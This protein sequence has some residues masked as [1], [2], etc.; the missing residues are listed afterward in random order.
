LDR[1]LSTILEAIRNLFG[2]VG[3]S[4]WLKDPASGEVV[5]QQAAGFQRNIVKGWRLAPGEGIAGW[6]SSYG[7]SI[8]L[9]DTR[10]DMRHFRKVADKMQM[11]LRSIISVPMRVKGAVIGALQ[12]V[13][14]QVDRF[15]ETH[16]E[17]LEALA[18]ASATAI[19]NA[20]LYERANREITERKRAQKKLK[21]S[22]KEL[23]DKSAALKEVNTALNVLLKNREEDVFTIGGI[24]AGSVDHTGADLSIL[25]Q[26]PVGSGLVSLD[27]GTPGQHFC[28]SARREGDK[29]FFCRF[30][31]EYPGLPYQVKTPVQC[32]QPE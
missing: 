28:H 11:E 29:C 21:A 14:K 2:V 5:C 26:Q 30:K 22:E 19:E 12:M 15:D 9:P 13:D 20:Q 31:L 27:A 23:R 3:S 18:D 17:L 6:V 7:E 8:I 16:G 1:V 10:K 32:L 24:Q 4:I 25:F